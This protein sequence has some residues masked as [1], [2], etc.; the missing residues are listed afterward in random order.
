MSFLF[1]R[2][3]P[4]DV[5]GMFDYAGYLTCLRGMNIRPAFVVWILDMPSWYGYST[6]LREPD[7]KQS[8]SHP[9]TT[10]PKYLSHSN[11]T[12]GPKKRDLELWIDLG[13][14]SIPPNLK[15]FPCNQKRSSKSKEVRIKT[16]STSSTNL[17]TES[18]SLEK[19]QNF[20]TRMF[21]QWTS[22]S[23]K[24]VT[25]N[26]RGLEGAM[27]KRVV[28]SMVRK[29]KINFLCIQEKQLELSDYNLCKK[30]WDCSDFDLGFQP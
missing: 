18:G 1:N 17:I 3:N 28:S 25:L 16:S 19:L 12:K 23:M 20:E 8:L 2:V 14:P 5:N 9:T 7:I 26:V 10:F 30:L 4:T 22:S 21:W 15:G 24:L 27:K 13:H 6:C 11:P 29:A